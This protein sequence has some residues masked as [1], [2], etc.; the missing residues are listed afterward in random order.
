MSLSLAVKYRPRD[1]ASVVEQDSIKIILQNQLDTGEIKNSYLF[2]GGAGTGKA[3]PLYSKILTPD[4]YIT[5][6]DVKVGTEVYTRFGTVA[7]V[8]GIFPQGKRPIYEITLQD[9]TKIRVSDS[10]LNNVYVY[11]QHKK[12][13]ESY[14]LTTLDLIGFI[15]KSRWKVRIDVPK[16]HF[17]HQDVLIDPYLLG[18]LIGDGSLANGNF[19]FSNSEQDV[20]DK[21]N[22]ILLRDYNMCLVHKKGYD[23]HIQY[24][25]NPKHNGSKGNRGLHQLK[26]NYD[27]MS[28]LKGQLEYYG[29]LCKSVDKHIPI[30]YL[31]NDENVRV[32]LLQ[33]LFDT[34]GYTDKN[35]ATDFST[36]SRQLSEDFAFLVRSLGIR[37]TITDKKPKYKKNNE[38]VEC[39]TSYNHYLHM[40]NDFIYCSSNKHL[41]RYKNRQHNPIRNIVSIEYIGEEEC[42][43]IM[44]DDTDHTY[45][46]D[47]FIPTHNTTC[48]RI[49]ANEINKG[50]GNPIE[51]D[52]ASNSGVADVR[53]ISQE[54]KL[55]SLDSEYK[56]FIIDEAHAISNTGWQAFLKLI[57]EPPAKSI[58]IFCTTD[59]QQIPKTIISRVQRY[60]FKRISE[61]GIVDRLEYI[62]AQ[63]GIKD[64]EKPAVEYIAKL[65]DGGMRD[66][67]TLM[68]KSLSFNDKL[69][70]E[71]VVKALGTVDYKLMMDLT[72]ALLNDYSTHALEVVEEVH[73][74][75]KDI[76]QFINLYVQFLLDIQKYDLTNSFKYIQIPGTS[77]N[78]DWLVKL[79]D[80]DLDRCY[81]LLDIILKLNANIKWSQ[82]PKYD[83]EAQLLL[84]AMEGKR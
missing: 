80:K 10:H 21:V 37:D 26:R 23:Y 1:W 38:Y 9:N 3:Q 17:A 62:L 32:Q 66:S 55:K 64:Y 40:P 65:A 69:T 13:R 14:V 57:E 42:Q 61:Q 53:N 75:G 28:T 27:V 4:G 22:N 79:E 41:S 20:I 12:E 74:S 68:D 24:V 76:K 49:F 35:G 63:E 5:M 39:N 73:S 8:S 71:N 77:E 59:P 15:K 52:A 6:A 33:G 46:S 29:L 7:K 16:V 56:V 31:L 54:A 72:D 11:N 44:V 30:Q 47:D 19:S 25:V 84:F 82:T 83:L 43:C 2:V 70:L 67:I 36:S 48:A 51:M 45:I 78:T 81:D 18:A 58:F 34:D 60:D 50:H